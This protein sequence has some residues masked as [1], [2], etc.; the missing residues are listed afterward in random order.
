LF[1]EIT[2]KSFS[3]HETTLLH[4]LIKGSVTFIM[5]NYFNPLLFNFIIF[6][7]H[8]IH[9]KQLSIRNKINT[10]YYKKPKKMHCCSSHI[11]N[12]SLTQLPRLQPLASAE[13]CV[14]IFLLICQNDKYN[15]NNSCHLKEQTCL[16]VCTCMC[17]CAYTHNSTPSISCTV[18]LLQIDPTNFFSSGSLHMSTT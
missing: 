14:I 9:P 2:Q 6:I 8:I 5:Q 15:K 11:I 16:Q 10:N 18:T 7:F 1:L 17:M 12:I 4:E 3:F 13:F